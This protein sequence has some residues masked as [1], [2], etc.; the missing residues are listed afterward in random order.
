MKKWLNDFSV[1]GI[2]IE[3]EDG[4]VIIRYGERIFEIFSDLEARDRYIALLDALDKD[5]EVKVVLSLNEHGCLGEEPYDKY[6]N[7]L[8]GQNKPVDLETLWQIQENTGRSRQLCFHHQTITKRLASKKLIIDGLQGTVVTPFFGE[9]LSADI[10]FVSEDLCFSL[11]H[12]KYGLHPTGGLAYFLPR[13]VGQ[14]RA[15]EILLTID[16]INAKLAL[17]LGLVSR[18]FANEDFESSCIRTAKELA[19]LSPATIETKKNYL[20][21][22]RKRCMIILNRRQNGSIGSR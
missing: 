13:F 9:S 22:M 3:L 14:G 21:M 2:S 19:E 7:K 4:V 10:R 1:T 18:I 15:N 20:F 12:K 17:D 16:V 8:S 11:A 5:P 6:I